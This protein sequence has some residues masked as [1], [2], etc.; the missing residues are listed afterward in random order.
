M[1]YGRKLDAG[2]Y[3]QWRQVLG[4]ATR[5][6]MSIREFC[7]Q[8]RIKEPQF[9]WWQRRLKEQRQQRMSGHGGGATNGEVGS[10]SFALVSDLPAPWQAGEAGALTA[11]IELVLANGRRLR[12]G[13]GVDEA[14][15]RTV[16]AALEAPPC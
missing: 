6:G 16:L 15:L 1:S 14:S 13:R 8:R 9:Y 4:E 10:G 2:K 11:G 7:R 12:I 5:N 3:R